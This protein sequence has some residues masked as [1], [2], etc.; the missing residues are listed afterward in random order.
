MDRTTPLSAHKEEN[1][2]TAVSPVDDINARAVERAAHRCLARTG[3][4]IS[5]SVEC[6]FRNGTM[7]LSGEVASYFHKQIAQEALL[8]TEHVMQVVNNLKVV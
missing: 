5:K 4:P 7:T 8:N 2:L 6:S 3:Y 1:V